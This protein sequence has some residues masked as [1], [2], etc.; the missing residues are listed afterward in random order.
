MIRGM[1]GAVLALTSVASG[2]WIEWGE[3]RINT[4]TLEIR[5]A[6]MAGV[7]GSTKASELLRKAQAG[8]ANII[9]AVVA[10]SYSY[11]RGYG[12]SGAVEHA[13]DGGVTGFE[14]AG[15]AFVG[16]G[17][18]ATEGS[19]LDGK[20]PLY[21]YAV[22]TNHA[23]DSESNNPTA[24]ATFAAWQGANALADAVNVRDAT[25]IT[26]DASININATC[27]WYPATLADA[28]LD[29]KNITCFTVHGEYGSES[30]DLETHRFGIRNSNTTTNVPNG[31]TGTFK[32]ATI[33]NDG[34][35]ATNSRGETTGSTA[36]VR[37]SFSTPY[38][39]YD[40]DT[41]PTGS[42][43]VGTSEATTTG[44]DYRMFHFFSGPLSG[45]QGRGKVFIAGTQVL[46]KAANAGNSIRWT[47]TASGGADYADLAAFFDTA[48][49]RGAAILRA[50][51]MAD[52]F[53]R[54]GD[55]RPTYVVFFVMEDANTYNTLGDGASVATWQTEI[56]KLM[57]NLKLIGEG[58]T[59]VDDW[60]IMHIGQPPF[61]ADNA[62]KTAYGVAREAGKGY[63]RSNAAT[64]NIQYLDPTEY[65]DPANNWDWSL[66]NP[67]TG[68]LFYNDSSPGQE[69]GNVHFSVDGSDEIALEAFE[70]SLG[71]T[72]ASGGRASRDL[73]TS[74]ARR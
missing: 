66:S 70:A 42:R 64:H 18:P 38:P 2:Q 35:S 44:L 60:A 61:H 21:T 72:D 15:S 41:N 11:Y 63:A 9:V 74:R 24:E 39:T 31:V 25:T 43:I 16:W 10:P 12:L 34:S 46:R 67:G 37:Q 47:L 5:E 33:Q 6:T 52:N 13:L 32:T 20:S 29:A 40:P 53:G 27:S 49:E 45:R 30:S 54:R 69:D 3:L 14:N 62:R 28:Q 73:R 7:Y 59:S 19:G 55:T 22:M 71:Y 1:M 65:T 68:E 36:L 50:D 51:E 8:N 58:F 26:D 17:R 48:G 56:A 23:T 57:D 4:E